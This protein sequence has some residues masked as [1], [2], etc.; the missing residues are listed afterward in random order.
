MSVE[1]NI[2]QSDRTNRI[3]IGVLLFLAAL[4]GAG[5]VFCLLAGV[6]LIVEG[7]IGWCAIPYVMSQLKSK[8]KSK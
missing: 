3:V 1:C 6:V 8:S 7:S 5:R 2:D 4:L